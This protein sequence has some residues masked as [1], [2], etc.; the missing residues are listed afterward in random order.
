VSLRVSPRDLAYSGLFGAAALLLPTIFHLVHLGRA[1]MPMYLPIMALA[2][3]VRP[4]P[5]V[6]TAL[7]VPLLSGALTGMPPFYPP[8]APCM[9]LELAAM[10][11]IVSVVVSAWP[12]ANELLVLVPVLIFG[13]AL[14][15]VLAYASARLLDLPAGFVAGISF[16]AGWPGVVLM[17]VAVPAVA[18]AGRAA[19]IRPSQAGG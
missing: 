14:G 13:R 9:A 2:F 7:V 11:A 3:F 17:I 15:V 6:I 10:A 8:V 19:R 16:I 4:L 5:A 18:R 1:L 12:R